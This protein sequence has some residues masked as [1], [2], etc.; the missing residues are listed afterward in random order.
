MPLR[1]RLNLYLEHKEFGGAHAGAGSGYIRASMV[2]IKLHRA[3][4]ES[5]KKLL[6]RQTVDS[7]PGYM[8]DGV[9]QNMQSGRE[10]LAE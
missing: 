5:L 7:R 4:Q 8:G 2:S 1:G 6:G 9:L 10:V 3:A